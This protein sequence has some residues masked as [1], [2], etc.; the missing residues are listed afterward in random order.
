M[1]LK[2]QYTAPVSQQYKQQTQHR[3]IRYTIQENFV[4]YPEVKNDFEEWYEKQ[5]NLNRADFASVMHEDYKFRMFDIRNGEIREDWGQRNALLEASRKSK[6]LGMAKDFD[7]KLFE[8]ISVDYIPSEKAFIIR[9]GGGRAH[10]AFLN[11][12][13]KVPAF[14]RYVDTVEESRRLFIT[15]DKNAQAISGYDKFLQHLANPKS[16]LHAKACDTFAISRSC[17]ICLSSDQK[18]K[19]IPLVEGIGTFQRMIKQCG[20]DVKGTKWG[21]MKA[22]NVSKAID[23]LKH[24]FPDNDEIPVSVLFALTAFIEAVQN[25]IPSG[26][27]GHERLVEFVNKCKE[28]DAELCDITKWVRVLKFDSSN[29]YDTY[30]AAALMKKWNE[31]FKNAN[32]GRKPKGF[33]RY[34]HWE[35]FEIETTYKNVFAWS[36]DQSL[37]T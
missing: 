29:H 19:E 20:G 27:A 34:V 22:P 13:Y 7:V 21:E 25:R 12:V 28:S 9:D 15:Q 1:V 36:R 32:K 3:K 24:C 33:Y 17:G 26:A 2:Q 23:V 6:I 18:S 14:V 4:A 37:F 35:D 31:V 10:A 5:T 11:G 30:G 16:N 8:P